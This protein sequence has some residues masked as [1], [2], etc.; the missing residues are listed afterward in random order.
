MHEALDALRAARTS[1]K[2]FDDLH[3]ALDRLKAG[4]KNKAGH[5]AEAARLTRKAI[6]ELKAKRKIADRRFSQ[7]DPAVPVQDRLNPD[8]DSL[9][10]ASRYR[11]LSTKRFVP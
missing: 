7:N 2:P 5:R 4:H 10:T 9:E 1:T 3:A 8:Q 6:D 11:V